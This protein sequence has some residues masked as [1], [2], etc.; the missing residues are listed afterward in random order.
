MQLWMKASSLIVAA[1]MIRTE[2]NQ[3]VDRI[4]CFSFASSSYVCC[5]SHQHDWWLLSAAAVAVAVLLQ[6]PAGWSVFVRPSMIAVV[7]AERDVALSVTTL[8][9]N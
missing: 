4:R 5:P 3:R 8:W 6:L 7:H 2:E 9:K 1:E